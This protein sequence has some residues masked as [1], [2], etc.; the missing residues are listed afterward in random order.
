MANST[1]DEV[2]GAAPRKGISP[3]CQHIAS[4]KMMLRPDPP[5]ADSDILDASQHCWCSQTMTILGPDG[6]ECHPEDCRSRSRSC[7]ESPLADLL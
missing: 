5:L 3:Y 7:F 2:Q 4:K 6:Y 1:P